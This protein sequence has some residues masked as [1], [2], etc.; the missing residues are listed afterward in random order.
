MRLRVESAVNVLLAVAACVAL[1]LMLERRFWGEPSPTSS[2]AS[3]ELEVARQLSPSEW[4]AVLDAARTTEDDGAVVLV[5]FVDV[6]CPFCARVVPVLDSLVLAVGDSVKLEYAHFPLSQH[7]FARAGAGA[8]ECARSQGRHRELMR[9]FLQ[10][11]DSIGVLGATEIALRAGVKGRDSFE[12][13]MAVADNAAAVNIGIDVGRR[14]GV[15]GTP[16]FVLDGRL[17]QGNP[18]LESLVRLTREA[19]AR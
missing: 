15:R 7:R 6:E 19:L 3:G 16:T 4:A 10:Q 8:V 1:A 14:I 2:T 18:T 17:L 5:E 11:Q 12:E 9:A 13:C